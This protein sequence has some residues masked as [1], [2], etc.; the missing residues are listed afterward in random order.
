MNAKQELEKGIND[1]DQQRDGLKGI[2]AT[3]TGTVQKLT[4][5][6][7]SAAVAYKEG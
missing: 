3:K 2:V 4:V 6:L 5:A 7:K 1:M